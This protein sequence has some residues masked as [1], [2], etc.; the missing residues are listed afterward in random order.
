MKEEDIR[1]NDRNQYECF[2]IVIPDN[3]LQQYCQ[4][5][6]DNLAKT[7]WVGMII[8]ANRPLRN[9]TFCTTFCN[10]LKQLTKVQIASLIQTV[11]NDFLNNLFFIAEE[12]IKE[13]VDN[14]YKC[15]CIVIPDDLLQQYCQRLFDNLTKHHHYS[16]ERNRLLMNITFRATFCT[17]I[18]QLTKAQIASIIQTAEDDFIN[19]MFVMTEQD[20]NDNAKNQYECFGIV[21]PS[22]LLQQYIQR[23]FDNFENLYHQYDRGQFEKNQTIDEFNI[24]FCFSYIHKTTFNRQN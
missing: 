9:V 3:L 14:H 21:I 6:C 10:Y 1:E 17:Y 8:I 7:V 4:R 12:D 11:E 23:W 16:V 15:F 5:L 19:E 24:S 18:N 20:I 13:N 2:G 22:V